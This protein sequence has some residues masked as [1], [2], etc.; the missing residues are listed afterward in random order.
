MGGETEDR[1][2]GGKIREGDFREIRVGEV[3]S[4]ETGVPIGAG[5]GAGGIVMKMADSL[6]LFPPPINVLGLLFGTPPHEGITVDPLSTVAPA[7]ARPSSSYGHLQ[8]QIVE[9]PHRTYASLLRFVPLA[10]LL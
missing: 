8:W 3:F 6:L 10:D 5:G 7:R 9:S 2:L 4:R 1:E